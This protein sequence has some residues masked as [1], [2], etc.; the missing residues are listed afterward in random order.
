M[1]VTNSAKL[2]RDCGDCGIS[3]S[4]NTIEDEN[5]LRIKTQPS[6]KLTI[7]DFL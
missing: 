1:L 2:A 7:Y 3:W 4:H 5:L 6:H